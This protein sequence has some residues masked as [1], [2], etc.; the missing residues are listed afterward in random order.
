MGFIE[1]VGM[2]YSVLFIVIIIAWL[3]RIPTLSTDTPPPKP[4]IGKKG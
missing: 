2:A 4:Y 3:N 1:I